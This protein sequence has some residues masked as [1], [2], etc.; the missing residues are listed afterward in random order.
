MGG[1]SS[2]GSAGSSSSSSNALGQALPPPGF[3]AQPPTNYV[4]SNNTANAFN[5]TSSGRGGSNGT[6]INQYGPYFANPMYSGSPVGV[7]GQMGGFGTIAVPWTQSNTNTTGMETTTRTNTMPNNVGVSSTGGQRIPR[8]STNLRGLRSTNAPT[9]A[10]THRAVQQAI[11]T[12][13]TLPS[14][15]G[16]QVMLDGNTFVLRG[17]VSDED[18]RRRTE[19][20]VRL[21]PGVQNVRNELVAVNGESAASR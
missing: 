3:V 2:S 17:K 1:N 19:N 21:T 10:V 20:M 18:E 8:Y 9:A 7:L 13:T 5:G 12:S 6:S 4:S 11:A 15:P 14:A 16:I